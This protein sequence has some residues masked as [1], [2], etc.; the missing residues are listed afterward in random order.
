MRL[1]YQALSE[2]KLKIPYGSLL[3]FGKEEVGKTSLIRQ[4][5]GLVFKPHLDRTRGID[6]N[7]VDTVDSRNIDAKTWSMEKSSDASASERFGDAVLGVY[8]LQSCLQKPAE[9]LRWSVQRVY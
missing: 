1:Y 6:N 7:A 5:A 2:G 3:V 9:A 4:L 8:C